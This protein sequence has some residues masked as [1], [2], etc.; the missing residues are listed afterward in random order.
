MKLTFLGA[1]QTVTGSKYLLEAGTKKILIDC[2]LFQGLKILRQ[3]NW[4]ELP[5]DLDTIDAVILTHAHIDHSGYFP[6]LYKNGYR[7]PVYCTPATRDLCA[8]L[9]RDAGYLQ[10]EE[11]SYL[12]KRKVSKHHPALPL[13]TENDGIESLTLFKPVPFKSKFVIGDDISVTFSPVGHILGAS[14]VRISYGG[15]TI[16]FSGDVGRPNDPIMLPPTPI[17][18]ADYLVLESTYGNR[19]H[20]QSDPMVQMKDVINRTV[21]R[22]G[23]LIVPA[24]AVGRAQMLLYLISCLKSEKAIPNVPVYLNSPMAIQ[25]TDLFCQHNSEHR[26]SGDECQSAFSGV[27]YV[28]TPEES[29]DLNL[30][31]GPMIIITA[32]GMVTGGR[33]LHHLKQFVGDPRNTVLFAGFQAAGTRGEAMV[34]GVDR[35]KIHGDY[36]GINAE[37]VSID[38]L[39]AHA[40]YREL[41]DWIASIKKA[42]KQTFLVHG[43][44]S[45]QDNLR[46]CIID[47]LGWEVSVPA[48]NESVELT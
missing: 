45:A 36:Y 39:S 40:D 47:E 26:L 19:R 3:R 48:Y 21:K 7:G 25:A 42:P 34:H 22:G 44:P 31:E 17:D 23:V 6:V 10:E 33:V 4:K 30:K 27:Q 14:S 1:T 37:V 2:G 29:K 11:A 9:L 13:F 32:S 8:I 28:R 41:L 46:R 43:E 5:V 20:D 24:F 35:I 12:N 16:V 15:K 18:H 38:S